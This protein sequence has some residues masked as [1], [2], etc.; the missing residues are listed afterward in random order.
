MPDDPRWLHMTVE[1][2]LASDPIS[3]RLIA[4]STTVSFA[5]WLELMSAVENACAAASSHT[6]PDD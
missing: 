5:G 1:A 3:G 4:G 6:S 2:D